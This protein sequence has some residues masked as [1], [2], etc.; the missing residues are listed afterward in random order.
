MIRMEGL[1]KSY[2]DTA[3][4]DDTD[5]AVSRGEVFGILG[6]NGAGKTTTLEM[7]EG[8][9]KPD[10]GTIEVAG[11]DA[12]KDAEGL[13]RIIGVQLQTTALFDYLNP[14]ETLELFADLYGA[15]SSGERITEILRMVSLEEKTKSRVEELSGGQQQRLSIALA[16]VNDP[17][18]VFLDEPESSLA[19]SESSA[20]SSASSTWAS[21]QSSLIRSASSARS[22]RLC[23][24]SVSKAS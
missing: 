11:Y 23:E 7:I 10:G 9:R 2:G 8:L 3:A 12:V 6:P 15:D 22:T 4:V 16:L 5:L 21:A 14:R 13:K 1:R 19:S 24:S 20:V 17:R 18:V